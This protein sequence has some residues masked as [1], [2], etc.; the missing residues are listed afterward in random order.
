MPKDA[1]VRKEQDD[2]AKDVAGVAGQ[3][4]KSL[5][6]RIERLEDEKK[7]LAD[8]VKDVYAEAKGVGFDAPTIRRIVKLRKMEPEK[9]REQDELLDLY[10]SA[11]GMG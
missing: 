3:R 2:E 5:I 10:K 6:E 7:G 11:I 1:A 9:I 8:D 4:L